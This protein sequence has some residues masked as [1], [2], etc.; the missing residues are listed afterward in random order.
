MAS[1]AAAD[2]P[3]AEASEAELMIGGMTCASCAAR[4]EKKL[5]RMDGVTATVNYATEKARVT[6][7][8][9]LE[10]GVP[11]ATVE[12]TG[13]TARPAP[14]PAPTPSEATAPPPPA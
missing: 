11:V 10:L 2:F 14:G 13:Y 4:V 1:T 5:N 7:G 12:Q 3:T 6:F 8:E 9:G